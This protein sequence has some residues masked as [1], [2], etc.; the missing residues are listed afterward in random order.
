[1][2]DNKGNIFTLYSTKTETP[3]ATTE[4]PLYG[5][6]YGEAGRCFGLLFYASDDI[7]IVKPYANLLEVVSAPPYEAIDLLYS[8]G[9]IIHIEG[10]NLSDLVP[11]INRAEIEG[12]G[13][14]EEGLYLPP[15]AGAPLITS[16][17]H[18]PYHDEE[19]PT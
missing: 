7:L 1:M 16:I 13:I 3:V 5:P 11:L 2:A 18:A 12:L 4:L 14:Y 10:T 8:D 15:A 9:G 19:D 6:V 17:T